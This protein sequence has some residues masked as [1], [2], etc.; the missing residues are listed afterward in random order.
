MIYDA[1]VTIDPGPIYV[2]WSD[3]VLG[4]VASTAPDKNAVPT[5]MTSVSMVKIFFFLVS[6]PN[7]ILTPL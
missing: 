7:N 4:V 1:S 6:N 2:G 5:N 3:H